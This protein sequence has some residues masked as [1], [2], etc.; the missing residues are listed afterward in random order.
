MNHCLG[1]K[2]SIRTAT[3]A[4]TSMDIDEILEKVIRWLSDPRGR[5]MIKTIVY[6]AIPLI[7]LWVLRKKGRPPASREPSSARESGIRKKKT[8]DWI[9]T[10]SLQETMAREQKK[11]ER[12]LAEVFGREDSTLARFNRGQ[13]SADSEPTTPSSEPPDAKDVLQEE[14]LRLFS[15]RPR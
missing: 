11:M 9:V 8:G 6:V 14:L 15:R 12:Q 2:T 5:E 10:E 4:F 1:L 3:G 13:K 7:I